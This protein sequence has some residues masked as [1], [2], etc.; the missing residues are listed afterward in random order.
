MM[1]DD[2]V[3]SLTA[4]THVKTS[5][6]DSELGDVRHYEMRFDRQTCRH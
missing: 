3:D 6:D 5:R 2:D 1:G 4:V